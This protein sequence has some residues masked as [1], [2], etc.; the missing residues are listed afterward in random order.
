MAKAVV[1]DR[2]TGALRDWPSGVP[3]PL[4]AFIGRE[5]ELP[6]VAALVL[7]GRLVTLI[8]AGGVGKTRLAIEAAVSV[9]SAFADGV[10]LVDLSAVAA[11][12]LLP[13]T[14]AAALGIEERAGPASVDRLAAVLR[15]QQRLLVL[16]NCEHLREGCAALAADLLSRCPQMTV[17]A[18]SRESLSVPGEVTW[19]VPSLTFPWPEHLPALKELEDFEAAALFLARARAAHPGLSLGPADVAAVT[20]ICYHLDGIPLALELAAARVGAMGLEA[21][22]RR[23]TGSFELLAR[24]GGGPARHQ[25][26]R[27][28]VEWSHQLLDDGER[29]LFRRLAVF[30]GGWTL[31]AAESACAGPPVPPG[32]VARL[33][34]GLADKSLVHVER[35][36]RGTRYRLLEV[37]RAFAHERLGASGE[38]ADLRMRHARYF[39]ELGERSAPLLIGPQQADRARH[40]DQETE[41]LRAAR[42]WCAE[43]PARADVGLRLASGLWEYWHIRGRLDEGSGWLDDALRAAAEPAGARAAALNGLGVIEMLRGKY[44]HGLEL[45]RQSVDLYAELGDRCGQSRALTHLGNGL[46]LTGDAPGSRRVFDQGLAVAKESGDDWHIAFALYLGGWAA[47]VSGDAVTARP[48]VAQSRDL[49]ARTGDRR[50]VGYALSGL[51]NAMTL[52]GETAEALPVLRESM[53]IFSELQERWGVLVV[54]E[55]LAEAEAA[56]GHWA[57]VA[58]LAGLIDS[59]GER[60]GGQL[61]PHEQSALDELTARA[62]AELGTAFADAR[63][64]GQ[65]IGRSDSIAAA[66]WPDETGSGKLA[67]ASDW[68]LTARECEVAE[69]V[70]EGLTNR[71]IAGRLFIA[72]RTVDTHVARI[73]AKLG[74]TSRAQV[75]AIVATNRRFGEPA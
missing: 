42:R 20:S 10:D 75:A 44:D 3:A 74:C 16:D 32:H 15:P 38:E 61:F 55:M 62:E 1:R 52:D 59:L 6:E 11:A 51:G 29:A 54:A 46:A 64:V 63:T 68:P 34:A 8:G 66:L 5:R 37:I 69:L 30:A 58:N 43:D 40:L 49:F 18:T 70:T 60:I 9:R 65:A 31:E 19:R 13:G 4:T 12:V 23:L 50:A 26:L 67:V 48:R 41:N 57:M 71:Q 24:S 45:F 53:C 22:A 33:L 27:A 35:P 39:A 28:S 14:I 21:I 73:L 72:E 25:T 36:D 2:V 7:A 47:T 56:L 17:L